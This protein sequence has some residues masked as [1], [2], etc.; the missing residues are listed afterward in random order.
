MAVRYAVA[1]GN[2]SSAWTWDGFT[3]IPA[4]GDVVHSNGF[5]VTI[6]Q[7]ITVGTLTNASNVSPAVAAGG[8]FSVTTTRT[9]N[10][11]IDNGH[12]TVT[13]IQ[14]GN[15]TTLTI[16]GNL[17]GGSAAAVAMN[18]NST[19]VLTGNVTASAT[20]DFPGLTKTTGT[21]GGIWTI[22]GNIQADKGHGIVYTSGLTT[23]TINGNCYGSLTTAWKYGYYQHHNGNV[24][25]NGTCKGGTLN[26]TF[27]LYTTRGSYSTTVAVAE[28]ADGTKF[29]HGVYNG[30]I[31]TSGSAGMVVIKKEVAGENG[32]SGA[33]IASRRPDA[34]GVLALRDTSLVLREYTAFMNAV[35]RRGGV[36]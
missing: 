8:N 31:H 26:G 7:D 20:A 3:T 36:V 10:A 25:V 27:G 4:A 13:L 19:L 14:T 5:I 6:N 9:I 22:T 24:I 33:D 18:S 12:A 23:I 1:T 11:N 16:N 30:V 2:W 17:T 29:P 32:Q 28:G 35:G 15:S 34:G 21:Y